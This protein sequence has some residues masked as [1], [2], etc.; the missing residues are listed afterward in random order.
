MGK[1]LVQVDVI[2]FYFN[3]GMIEYL[4]LK[5]NKN[6][7]GFWQPVTG[8]VEEGESLLFAARREVFEESGIDKVKNIY[9]L[10][11]SFKYMANNKIITEHVFAFEAF[12]KEINLQRGEHS[13]YVWL[14]YEDAVKLLKWDTNID[15]FKRLNTYLSNQL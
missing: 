11:Y 4:L 12:N 13:N 5:R 1:L 6:R 3:E 7:G 15:S 2:I 14:E 10:K 9:D 8:G